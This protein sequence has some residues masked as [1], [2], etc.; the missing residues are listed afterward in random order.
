V[1]EF[2]GYLSA[3]FLLAAVRCC[4]GQF[5]EGARELKKLK[6]S[7]IGAGLAIS[8]HTLAQGLQAAGQVDYARALLE[9]ACKTENDNDDVHALLAMCKDTQ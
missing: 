6:V 5:P 3:R 2:P 7:Q 8:C 1:D 4:C 9:A